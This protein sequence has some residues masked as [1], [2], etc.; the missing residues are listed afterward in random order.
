M[1]PTAHPNLSH[2]KPG[3]AGEMIL[4]VETLPDSGPTPE[5]TVDTVGLDRIVPTPVDNQEAMAELALQ[6]ANEAC[7]AKERPIIR[8]PK[9][10]QIDQ[11]PLRIEMTTKEIRDVALRI[12][13]ARLNVGKAA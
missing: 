1:S 6:D 2:I 12:E 9:S 11:E 4:G 10:G 13:Y 7:D 5:I 3:I 8:E